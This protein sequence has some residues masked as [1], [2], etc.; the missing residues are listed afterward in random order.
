VQ[1]ERLEPFEGG[2]VERP[3]LQSVGVA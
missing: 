2:P 1:E 3:P